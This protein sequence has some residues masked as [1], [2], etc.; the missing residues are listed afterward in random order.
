[1]ARVLVL[2]N[3]YP[4]HHYGGYEL[5]CHDVVARWR[6]RGHTVEVV[7]STECVEGVRP[8]AEEGVHRLLRASWSRHRFRHR[9]LPLAARDERRNRGILREAL[10][11]AQPDVVSVWNLAGLPLGLLSVV[12]DAGVPH[13]LVV[14]NEWPDFWP[15]IDPWA[16]RWFT[17]PVDLSRADAVCYVSDALR[18]RAP[19][20]TVS[21]VVYSGIDPVDFPDGGSPAVRPWAWRLLYVGRVDPDKGIETAVRALALL[22]RDATLRVVGRGDDR[23]RRRLADLAASLGVGDRVAFSAAERRELVAVYRAADVVVF[24][25]VWEEP[26]GLVPIEAM[27]S[28]TPVV[29]TGTGGSAE[30]LVD[31]ANAL[32]FP[33]G[34]ARALAS[35]VERLASDAPLRD[36][37]RARGVLTARELTVDRLADVLEEWHL[38]AA[39]RFAD[40]VPPH[41]PAPVL[42]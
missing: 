29:A 26:F 25:P 30:Y 31:G 1:M 17:R 6:R 13:V 16:R 37:L 4:P 36:R 24:P 33:V 8:S 18:R 2:S 41:R 3:L 39:S 5:S 7:T 20:D 28:G 42:T 10:D 14:C 21:T 38:A 12:H 35:A 22:P 34:D 23:E 19:I 27:A 11:A 32:L 40:G 9:P 15:R